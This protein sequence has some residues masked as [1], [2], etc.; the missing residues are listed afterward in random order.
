M[1]ITKK[2]LPRRTFLKGVGA[3][4]ALPLLDGM[5]PALTAAQHTAAAPARRLGIVYVPNGVIMDRWTPA[6]AGADF[7]MT[8]ILER[9][10]PFRNQMLVLSGLNQNEARQLPG[11]AAGDH[12]RACAAFLTG[13]HCKE[14]AGADATA[15]ISFDQL[16]ARELGKHT[17]L[18]SLELGIES[19]DVVGACI[20]A[21]SCAYS[22]TFS[23]STPN[24]PLPMENQPRAVF[25][26]LFG[27]SDSTDSR[28]RLA[29]IRKNRSILDFVNAEVNRLFTGLGPNDRTKVNQYLD[30]IRDVERRIQMAEQQSS[31][32]LPEV[33]R[34]GSIPDTFTDHIK[35]M[36]DL[37]VLAFQTDMTRVSSLMVGH[38]MSGQSYPEIGFADPYHAV[39]H[40]QGDPAAIE[41]C[42]RVNTFHIDMFAYL[43]EKM[44]ATPD[45]SG[46]LL[47]HSI[48]LYGSALSDGNL[49]LTKNLPVLVIGGGSGRLKGGRHLQFP[50]DTP[51]NNLFLTLLDRLDIP[52]EH[53][54]DSTGR[55]EL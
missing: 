30:A 16:A 45:G 26:R 7:E 9:L 23:W 18:S 38:E 48:L 46:S 50:A 19:S 53:F 21:Y 44:R 2:A 17:Q 52:A 35:L 20:A 37:Q 29:R 25:E 4:L 41:K 54:G 33:Q 32:Q 8:P 14:T 3:S 43:L 1:I 42:V 47:D 28:E 34:P 13:V 11:E 10:A 15:G 22:N 40:H 12:P 5:V 51:M 31:R 39:T 6:A 55:L 24:T 49:H 27:D 36:F